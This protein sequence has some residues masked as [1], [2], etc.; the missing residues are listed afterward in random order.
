MI[1][2]TQG[3]NPNYSQIL[4]LGQK[5]YYLFTLIIRMSVQFVLIFEYFK[6]LSHKMILGFDRTDL[7]FLW[8]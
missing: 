1:T 7:S 2:H 3:L 6:N 8:Q 5:S 4:G